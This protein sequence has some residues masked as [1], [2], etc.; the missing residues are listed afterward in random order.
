MLGSS[1]HILHAS[2][3]AAQPIP[4]YLSLNYANLFKIQRVI[5]PFPLRP[6]SFSRLTAYLECPNCAL[7]QQRKRRKPE[8]QHFTTLHQASLFAAREPDPRLVGTLL[9]TVVDLLHDPD[10]PVPVEQQATLLT[11]PV[12]MTRFLRH[13]LLDALLEMGKLKL[14]MFYDE[15]AASE[16][17]LR[18][19]L[20]YPMLNYQ[21]VLARTEAR[22]FASAERFQFKLLSTSKTFAGHRDWGGYVGLVGE[23]DQIRLHHYENEGVRPAIMEFKKGLGKKRSLDRWAA[24]LEAELTSSLSPSPGQG[25]YLREPGLAHAF[26]LMVYW[27]AFQTRWDVME[28]VTKARGQVD[29][30]LMPLHQELDLILYNLQDSS[31]YLLVPSDFEQALL[32]VTTCIFYTNWAMKS[33]YAWQSPEHECGKTP[34]ISDVPNPPIQVGSGFLSAEACYA[35]ARESFQRFSETVRWQKLSPPRRS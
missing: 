2:E 8:P 26:Q 33:G 12:V 20:L 30:L 23:F 18:S 19:L 3:V 32:A 25:D 27:L 29:E 9:H 22:V 7:A 5:N 34:P 14:A 13:H 15:V 21:R 28:R 35:L 16:E 10:G 4:Q 11:E 24:R 6:V 17:T 31:Q 1:Y